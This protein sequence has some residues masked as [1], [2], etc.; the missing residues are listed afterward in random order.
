M[1]TL[2]PSKGSIYE[3]NILSSDK[4][5]RY[6]SRPKQNIG[7]VDGSWLLNYNLFQRY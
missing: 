5:V 4:R 3:R 2:H 7:N 1:P 6:F